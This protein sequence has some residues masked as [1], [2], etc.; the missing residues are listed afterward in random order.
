[1]RSCAPA[2]AGMGTF[3]PTGCAPDR[4]S[5]TLRST[6]G[7]RPAPLRGGTGGLP[8]NGHD[9]TSPQGGTG[10]L[11]PNGHDLTSPQRASGAE[12]AGSP[13]TGTT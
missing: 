7:Y 10:G 8:P 5:A 12:L 4:L 3:P 9:L 2:G 13:R 1:M 11:P 6:R